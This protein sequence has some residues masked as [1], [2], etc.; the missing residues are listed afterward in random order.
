MVGHTV[1]ED[2][3]SRDICRRLL[4]L[5]LL[6]TLQHSVPKIRRIK[7]SHT[8][9]IFDSLCLVLLCHWQK[10]LQNLCL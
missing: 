1:C 2:H 7:R 3:D 9:N 4:R 10:R 5:K 8:L 6:N